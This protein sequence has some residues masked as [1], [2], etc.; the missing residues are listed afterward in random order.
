MFY[1]LSIKNY[2]E[3]IVFFPERFWRKITGNTYWRNIAI[4][5]QRRAD[6]LDET[7]DQMENDKYLAY[8]RITEK[9]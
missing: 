1:M 4:T 9:L 7:I 8:K 5:E 2:I 3:I 6:S